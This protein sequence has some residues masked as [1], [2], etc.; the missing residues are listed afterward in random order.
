M[1]RA[2]IRKP[3]GP[4]IMSPDDKQRS[5]RIIRYQPKAGLPQPPDT[6][7]KARGITIQRILKS[8]DS[9][10]LMGGRQITI[11]KF[12]RFK[13]VKGFPAVKAMCYHRDPV[14]PNAIR[15]DHEVSVVGIQD[16]NLPLS[17]QRIYCS[18]DCE[19]WVFVWEYAVAAHGGTKVMYGNGE[20]PVFTNPELAAGA[21]KHVVAV[22]N[23]ILVKGI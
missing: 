23:E 11:T 16:P 20:P 12:K 8:C 4:R 22:F 7:T 21:C 6:P 14:R 5:V 3:S 9:L 13:T 10:R 17:K 1:A 18:C 15:R 2:P 19:D